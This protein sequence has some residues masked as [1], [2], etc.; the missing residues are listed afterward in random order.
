M[1]RRYLALWLPRFATDRLG[2]HAGPLVTLVEDAGVPRIAAANEAAALLGMTPGMALADARALYPELDTRRAN[3]LRER[4]SL[5]RLADWCDRYSPLIA[6][7]GADGLMIDITGCDHLFGGEAAM[8]ADLTARMEDFGYSAAAAIAPTPGAA[9][10]LSRFATS[11]T[12][13]G[14]LTA[15][16]GL[17]APLP[18][19]ALRLPAEC[20]A[21]LAQVGLRRTGD[22]LAMPR[23]PLARRFGAQVGQRLAQAL[24]QAAEAIAPR[25]APAPYRLRLDWMEPLRQ[26][27]NLTAAAGHLLGQLCERLEKEER[28]VRHLTVTCHGTDGH[29]H[30]AEIRTSAPSRRPARLLRLLEADLT[31][32]DMGFGIET[33]ILSAPQTEKLQAAAANF[34]LHQAGMTED[35]AA[36]ID[37]L[38]QRFGERRVG[39]PRP[40]ASYLPER[41][42]AFLPALHHPPISVGEAEPPA[43]SHATCPPRPLRLLRK[44]EPVQATALLPDHPPAAFRWRKV[45]HR[46]RQGGGPERIAP[47]W[48]RDLP[49]DSLDA[50]PGA[51]LDDNTRDYYLVED[52]AGQRFWLYRQG[53]YD[54]PKQQASEPDAA[55][56]PAWFLQGV[57]A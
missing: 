40:V 20:V 46:V 38:S 1:N 31:A 35:T 36:L 55:T 6:L 22:L 51:V 9:W 8:L 34:W 7:D 27:E 15:L 14:D 49:A 11:G 50:G 13:A 44:P 47:E 3:P 30:R 19:A 41:A 23:A 56:P 54:R 21:R 42:S 57:M 52:Q 4:C 26:P 18:L 43:Y 32:C 39:W 28:G 29:V 5:T 45:G 37:R 33:I 2:P 53:L 16:P 10:A 48:W 25:H 24:G 12:I 17:L